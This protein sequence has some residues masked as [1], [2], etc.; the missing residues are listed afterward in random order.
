MIRDGQSADTCKQAVNSTCT[1]RRFKSG[2]DI[3]VGALEEQI[4]LDANR[5]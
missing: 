1:G 4:I 2:A 5:H 3:S